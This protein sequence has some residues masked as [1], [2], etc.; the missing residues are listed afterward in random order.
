MMNIEGD[1][2]GM[3]DQ[4]DWSASLMLAPFP[5]RPVSNLVFEGHIVSD[6]ERAWI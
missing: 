6:M 2:L 1:V 4:I 5:V 3:H